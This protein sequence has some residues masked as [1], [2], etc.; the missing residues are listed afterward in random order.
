MRTTL[1]TFIGTSFVLSLVAGCVPQQKYDD[2]LTAE[3]C[4]YIAPDGVF[5]AT[6]YACLHS[7][8]Q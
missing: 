6:R 4:V 5:V 8:L 3:P 1:L 7:A 2:L